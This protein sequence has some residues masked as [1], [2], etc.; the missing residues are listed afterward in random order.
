MRH[1]KTL[2]IREELLFVSSPLD[3]VQPYYDYYDYRNEEFFTESA[4]VW[5]CTHYSPRT[6]KLVSK[7]NWWGYPKFKINKEKISEIIK[8]TDLITKVKECQ[9]S[10]TTVN[11]F[12]NSIK[13]APEFVDKSGFYKGDSVVNYSKKISQQLECPVDLNNIGFTVLISPVTSDFDVAIEPKNYNLK[14]NAE[15]YLLKPAITIISKS[16][17]NIYPVYANEDAAIRM[18]FDGNDEIRFINKTNNFI[19]IKSISIYYNDEIS[20]SNLSTPIELPP[21]AITKEYL[22]VNKY[23]LSNVK[24]F[25]NYKDMTRDNAANR[26]ISFGFAIKYKLSDQNIDKSLYKQNNYNLLQVL[27]SKK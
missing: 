4:Y 25:T 14:F 7:S 10:H 5:G 1:Y 9:A 3:Y 21:R 24:K 11:N 12:M 20:T 26:L 27:Q 15:G 23:V 8:Q 16:F 18:E 6:S 17:K 13:I 22:S 2:K 19:Q